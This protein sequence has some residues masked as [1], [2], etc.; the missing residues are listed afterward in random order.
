MRLTMSSSSLPLPLSSSFANNHS[1]CHHHNRSSPSSNLSLPP[2]PPSQIQ[3]WGSEDSYTQTSLDPPPHKTRSIRYRLSQLCREGKPHIARQLFDS[4]PRPTTVI[5]NTIIIGF[6]CNNM[7]EE[8][9]LFYARMKSSSPDTKCD[10]YTYSSTLKACA[11]TGQLKIGKS[12]HCQLLRSHLY[13]SRIVSNSLLNMYATCLSSTEDELGCFDSDLSR[14]DLVR[15]VFDTLRKRNVVAWNT[16]ISWCV[17]TKRYV[18]AVRHFVMMMKVGIKPT[19][20]SF[21]NVFPAVSRMADNNNA[22]VLYGL[23]LKLGSEYVNDLFAVSSA[24]CMFAELSSLDLATKVFKHCL[25]RNTEVWNTMIG[26]FV[27]KNHPLEAIGFF[28]KALE[29]EHSI[30][31]DNVTFLSALTAASQLQQLEFAQQLH[32]CTIKNSLALCVIVLNAIIVMYSR[33]N[34]IEMSFEVFSR[35]QERDVVSWNTM[36]SAFVQNGLDDEG[37][38]L[39]Y[40]MQKQ[41]FIID[42]VTITALLSAASNLRNQEIGR[43]AHAYLF[44]HGIQFAG[45]ESYLI[46]MY[47]KSGLIEVAQKLFEKNCILD[48]DQATWNAM[49]AGNTQNGLIE[50]AFIVFRQ[51]LEE[52]VTPNAVTFASILPACNPMGSMTLGKQLHGFAIRNSL[53]QNIFVCSALVDMYSKLGAITYAENVFT[54]S[55]ERNSV[56]FTNMILGYGQHGMGEKALSLFHSMRKS[57]IKPDAITFV[58]VLSACSYAGLV[59]EGLQIV[60]SMENEY[61][62]RPSPEHYC[63]VADMLGRVGRVVEAYEFV[64]KLGEEGNILGIWGSLLAACRIHGEFELGKIV[65]NKLLD[66]ERGNSMAGYHVLMSNM[67]AEEGN[68]EYVDR[69][70]RGMR[71]KGLM[72]EVGCSRIDLAGYV[73]SFASRDRKHPQ[74]DDIYDMLG[75]LTINIKDAGYRPRLDSHIGWISE[76][77]E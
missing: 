44:R 71:E 46:D 77:E 42:Y 19:V 51:M 68:W 69:V 60:E 28:L 54:N 9:I 25:E 65:A 3:P 41:G 50:Q 48:K 12:V 7:P 62:I 38:M 75:D 40:E 8:A 1:H 11:E 31:L 53:D 26:A 36:V 27:Q 73:N 37:L 21:V 4:I 56:T 72:K 76:S 29:S 64:E 14:Y 39:V 47:A 33:C 15:K 2:N 70:R 57:G 58:A 30:L 23:L 32:A 16:M 52:N 43:Q 59:D 18:E 74:C 5:W 49:I 63:C 55:P 10:V 34:C 24:I 61:R 67:Y 6:M 22:N 20:V 45:M 13:P 66:M 35:M 17:K